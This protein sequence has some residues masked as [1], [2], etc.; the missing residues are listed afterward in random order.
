MKRL[1]M[2][3]PILAL[4]VLFAACDSQTPEVTTPD[5]NEVET[6][7]P[8]TDAP[9]EAPTAAPTDE[10]ITLPEETTE[11]ESEWVEPE[12][13]PYDAIDAPVIE[14][15]D[16]KQLHG[17]HPSGNFEFS[18]G[19]AYSTDELNMFLVT[20]DRMYHGKMTATLIAPS[21][22]NNDNGIVFG[23]TEDTYEQYYFWE[24]GPVYYF[25]FVSDD[26]TLYLAKVAYNG[27][28]W[29][30]LFVT[31]APIANYTH[32]D[33][34]TISVEFDGEGCIDCY[35][36]DEWLISYFDYDWSYGGGYGIRCEVPEV[37]YTEV[38]VDRNWV[39]E[40]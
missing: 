9:T 23:M 5:T 28:A 33:V 25:L 2:L 26:C 15:L 7:A 39:S 3:V 6:T 40:F 14:S 16:G 21:Q 4:L 11:A 30:E 20:N 24:D 18:D 10:D 1:W 27:N 19:D 17:Y 32:G 29:T 35:A 31:S 13:V 34:I 8:Q 37:L 36:N 12:D 22:Y 38:I